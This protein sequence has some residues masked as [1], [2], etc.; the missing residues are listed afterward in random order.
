MP[1]DWARKPSELAREPDPWGEMPCA[2][3]ATLSARGGKPYELGQLPCVCVGVLCVLGWRPCEWGR[4]L[5]P[6][7]QTPWAIRTAAVPVGTAPLRE[8]RDAEIEGR[9]A[10]PEPC[11]AL[12]EPRDAPPTRRDAVRRQRA[13]SRRVTRSSRICTDARPTS[14]EGVQMPRAPLQGR[15]EPSRTSWDARR[16]RRDAARGGDDAHDEAEAPPQ[17]RAESSAVR[18][19]GAGFVHEGGSVRVEREPGP[20]SERWARVMMFASTPES[21]GSAVPLL[22]AIG[23]RGVFCVRGVP[24]GGGAPG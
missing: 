20:S 21:S 19:G 23:S 16:V 18:A 12:P 24:A 5:S 17:T 4:T 8:G 14:K 6:F 2:N 7:A 3:A 9:D 1:Y 11:D 22:R 15:D 10:L 13:D